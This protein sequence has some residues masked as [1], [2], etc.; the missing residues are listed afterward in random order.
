[1]KSILYLIPLLALMFVPVHTQ[2]RRENY[3]YIYN[4]CR[5]LSIEAVRQT[6]FGTRVSFCYMDA[7]H[8]RFGLGST[9]FANDEQGRRHHVT[10]T[11]GIQLDSVFYLPGNGQIYFTITFD[12]LSA[13][14]RFFDII[15][16]DDRKSVH[17]YGIHKED[18]RLTFGHY[19]EE[20]RHE[21]FNPEFFKPGLVYIRG[22]IHDYSR[23]SMNHVLRFPRPSELMSNS[24][25]M[26]RGY[27]KNVKVEQDGSFQT[28]QMIDRACFNS[29][30]WADGLGFHAYIYTRPGDT[31]DVQV[32]NPGQWNQRIICHNT[33]GREE[34]NQLMEI[35]HF[36][37]N[38][39]DYVDMNTL[40]AE[41]L[42]EEIEDMRIRVGVLLDYF[43]HKYRLTP[44][45]RHL[46]RLRYDLELNTTLRV[47][48]GKL[49][50]RN[51]QDADCLKTSPIPEDYF[52]QDISWNDSSLI[53]LDAAY[54]DDFF[55]NFMV[56]T[57]L[58]DDLCEKR[59]HPSGWEA[60]K[61][62]PADT[63]AKAFIDSICAESSTPFIHLVF[64]DPLK[65]TGALER[66]INRERLEVLSSLDY[67]LQ[68][69][70]DVRLLLVLNQGIDKI[71][72]DSFKQRRENN[73]ECIELPEEDFI[74]LQTALDMELLP[75][76]LTV[77]KDG[78]I[79]FWGRLFTNSTDTFLSK[80]YVLLNKKS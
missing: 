57:G 64:M 11:E 26:K 66:K 77:Q 56:A 71:K 79:L 35:W 4:N 34:Y 14:T 59:F 22:K 50:K 20:V 25:R 69:S 67:Y 40:S 76:D 36:R 37:P 47:Q 16:S 13:D 43:Y 62:V 28:V 10:D 8:A 24:E 42:K 52:L 61:Y 1:M 68:D 17:I 31:L 65:K 29:F 27:G 15:E 54:N 70:K 19:A 58:K 74:H 2:A 9:L 78:Q 3:T 18:E 49:E 39:M 60:R 33:K 51:P 44:W 12:A 23:D 38:L 21:E 63:R 80:L 5:Q 6:D 48:L 46:L 75:R 45:E 72:L 30:R 32:W 55:A 73:F 7:P 53:L 41:G